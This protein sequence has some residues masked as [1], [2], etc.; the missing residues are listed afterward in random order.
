[1]ILLQVLIHL[2]DS[3]LKADSL[4]L[5]SLRH[6][7]YDLQAKSGILNSSIFSALIAAT[8]SILVLAITIIY[9]KR[10]RERQD[11]ENTRKK[12][13]YFAATIKPIISYSTAQIANIRAQVAAIRDKTRDTRLMSFVPKNELE[14]ITKRL[15]EEL[16]FH[17]FTTH[18]K[19]YSQSVR[20]FKN[21]TAAI[22]YQDLQMDQL[23]D[24]VKISM[25]HDYD[26]RIT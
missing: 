4:K 7:V 16:F 25:A 17:A 9:N 6:F 20:G 1:M 2:K 22:E 12:L 15:D 10:E 21:I 23:L 14:K 5:D 8:I 3:T 19:P 26:R 24:M 11:R 18:Y 13:L